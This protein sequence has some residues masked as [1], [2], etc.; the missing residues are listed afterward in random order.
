MRG[1]HA[2]MLR[3]TEAKAEE[4]RKKARELFHRDRAKDA[5]VVKEREKA[6]EV[7]SA[8]TAKLKA[9]RLARDAQQEAAEAAAPAPVKP[10]AKKKAKKAE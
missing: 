8:K 6:F 10:A 1:E 9:L 4:A 3:P 7:Q 5:E 2:I